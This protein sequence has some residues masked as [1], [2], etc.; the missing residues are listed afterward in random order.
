MEDIVMTHRRRLAVLAMAPA[1][2]LVAPL[3][4]RAAA[5]NAHSA[6]NQSATTVQVTIQNFAFSPQTITIAPGTKVVWTQRDSAPHTVTS[7]NNAFPASNDLSSGQ[8]Y[9]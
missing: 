1:L 4:T 6:T 7:D 3:M 2:L 5:P 9:S 8:T